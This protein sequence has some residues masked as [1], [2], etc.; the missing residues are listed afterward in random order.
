MIAFKRQV[1]SMGVRNVPHK[2]TRLSDR[3]YLKEKHRRPGAL[4]GQEPH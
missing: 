3:R 1:L 2:F 4:S